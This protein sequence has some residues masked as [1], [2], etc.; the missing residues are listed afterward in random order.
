MAIFPRSV[1]LPG[2][3]LSPEPRAEGQMII[4]VNR[5]YSFGV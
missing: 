4:C 1:K 5:R 3:S 2:F